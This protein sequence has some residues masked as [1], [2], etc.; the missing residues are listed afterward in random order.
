MTSEGAIT[1]KGLVRRFDKEV[2][3][4]WNMALRGTRSLFGL[5]HLDDRA[6][7]GSTGPGHSG[8]HYSAIRSAVPDVR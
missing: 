5:D 4:D 1:N 6:R 8:T 3:V 2:Y 7:G